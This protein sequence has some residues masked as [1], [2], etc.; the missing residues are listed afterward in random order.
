MQAERAEK[1]EDIKKQLLGVVCLDV[2]VGFTRMSWCEKVHSPEER[3]LQGLKNS[4]TGTFLFQAD[5]ERKEEKK[6][7]KK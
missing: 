3:Y 2:R 4:C 1:K 6:K 5:A 7:K